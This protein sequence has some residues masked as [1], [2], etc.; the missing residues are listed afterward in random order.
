M[1]AFIRLAG[2]LVTL[3]VFTPPAYAQSKEALELANRLFERAGLGAQLASI[4]GEFE[5]GLSPN[6]GKLP[7]EMI[8]ALAEAGKKGFAPAVLR[9]EI[10]GSLARK[11]PAADMKRVLAWLEGDLG[12]RMTLAEEKAAGALTPEN[13]Q[14]WFESQKDKPSSSKRTRLIAE[15]IAATKAVEVGATFMEAISLGIAAGMDA[16]QPVEKRIGISTLRAR[17]RA[18]F[19]PD[20][21]R[22]SM[23]AALPAMYGYTYREIGD[24]DLAAYV[25]FNSSALGTR[26][27][28]AATAALGEALV[29]ASMRV[30]EFIQGT[31]EKKSI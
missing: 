21:L 18:Q 29:S 12:R 30:G 11:M 19:P 1:K 24:A 22:A 14:A 28:E 20:K 5:R 4:P 16:A 10:V 23:S 17:L 3:A 31:P 8:A 15:L 7:D 26:Y 9:E 6:R 13:M 27:N 2:M 25:K